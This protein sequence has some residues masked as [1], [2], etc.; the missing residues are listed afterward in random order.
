MG[1]KSGETRALKKKGLLGGL[2][3]SSRAK[4]GAGG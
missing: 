2:P 4:F 1:K 3:E